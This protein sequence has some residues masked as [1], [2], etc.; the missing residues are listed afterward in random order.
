MIPVVN[1]EQMMIVEKRSI[2]SQKVSITALMEA[3]G[4][5]IAEAVMELT[6]GLENP[7]V[8]LV[9]GKGNNGGDALVAA[10]HLTATGISNK[11]FL[12]SKKEALKGDALAN[13]EILLKTQPDTVEI[14]TKPEDMALNSF[15]IVVDAILGIGSSGELREPAKSAVKQFSNLSSKVVAVDMPTGVS[16]DN[17][18]VGE[19]Y[20]KAD[21]TITMGL[22]KMG[23]H[24]SPGR[25]L[26]GEVKIAHIGFP[27]SAMKD[28][29]INSFI[30]EVADIRKL[31]PE[32]PKDSYKHKRG[33]LL[34][35]G[36]SKGM[37]GAIVLSSQAA[38]SMGSGLVITAVPASLNPIFEI[39]LT[40]EMTLPLKDD[41][42]GY[43]TAESSGQLLEF[44]EW[45]DVILIGPGMGGNPKTAEFIIRVAEA[46]RIPM[47]ID[48]DALAAFH[49]RTSLL[50]HLGSAAVLTP[51]Y[52]EFAYL[53][54]ITIG[55]IKNDPVSIARETAV[56][57]G[58]NIVLKGAPTVTGVPD[59]NVYINNTGNP[60]L[61]TAG[62][63]D[64]LT[65]MIGS[66]ISQG[67]TPKDAA[68]AGSYLH[69]LAGDI[70]SEEMGE[71]VMKASDLI[72][73]FPEMYE[74]IK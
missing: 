70:A 53:F 47:V 14:V 40:E 54:D 34:A 51:H 58:V 25:E 6:N 18:A 38:L 35:V 30:P 55:M 13:L 64:V 12:L 32:L 8:A 49:E 17:G 33:K 57:Y 29:A 3:A 44:Y 41:S 1:S 63:G 73:F 65:G 42:K 74:S 22:P 4:L 27:A 26:C 48:A 66:L 21:T 20:V 31:I 23:Q 46:T 50:A 67:L 45:A 37:T 39:K 71:R 10:R 36:G 68:I 2:E 72:K 52:A 61:A 24:F 19:E 69:G 60:G 9:C 62:S 16:S 7:N 15:D 28:E 43:F 56:K 59:G 11:V 5:K